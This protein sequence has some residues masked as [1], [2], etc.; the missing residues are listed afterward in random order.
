ML[1]VCSCDCSGDGLGGLVF[2]VLD[3]V[4]RALETLTGRILAIAAAVREREFQKKKE[5]IA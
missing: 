2:C 5:V 4:D 3:S 1:Q